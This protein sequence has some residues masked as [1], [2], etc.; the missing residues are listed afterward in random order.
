MPLPPA[1]TIATFSA[2]IFC[3]L[4]R[5]RTAAAVF[6]VVIIIPLRPTQTRA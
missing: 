6:Q 3:S 5:T 1:V 2:G 4:Y